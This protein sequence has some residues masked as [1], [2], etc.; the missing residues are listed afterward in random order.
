MHAAG[1]TITEAM[2]AGRAN[3]PDV[4]DNRRVLG[5]SPVAINDPRKEFFY[6]PFA[7]GHTIHPH[8]I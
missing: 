8:H 5:P 4:N 6:S 7:E 2:H 3:H 1:G